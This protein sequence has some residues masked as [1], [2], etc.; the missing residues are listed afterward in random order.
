MG[1]TIFAIEDYSDI[2][3]REQTGVVPEDKPRLFFA[4]SS[5]KGPEE[6][7]RNLDRNTVE[8]LYITNK[9]TIFQKHG[10]P[11]LGTASCVNSGGLADC[12]RIV[13][14]DSKLAHICIAARVK[15]E[16]VPDIAGYSA[17]GDPIYQY[18]MVGGGITTNSSL[19][20]PSLPDPLVYKSVAMITY[21]ASVLS[22]AGNDPDAF[23][24][25]FDTYCQSVAPD[26]RNVYPT[27]GTEG[28]YP[29]FVLTDN[30]RGVSNKKIVLEADWSRGSHT[31]FMKYILKVF[32]E[33][34]KLENYAFSFNQD[35]DENKVNLSISNIVR[36][37][38]LQIRCRQFD[39]QLRAFSENVAFIAGITSEDFINSDILNALDEN[40]EQYDKIQISTSSI[41]FSQGIA[42]LNGDNG[43]FGDSPLESVTYT[44]RLVE[45]FNGS[46]DVRNYDEIYD[47]DNYRI[48]AIFDQ[49]YPEPVKRAI[50]DL[51]EFRQDCFY[52]RDM[53]LGLT[54]L[55]Q[56]Q[57]ANT[58]NL[59]SRF[60]ATY[61]NSWDIEDPFSYKPITVT[62][63][64]SLINR[65]VT[66]FL[67]GV[68]RPFAGIPFN[69]A[70]TSDEIIEGSVN[71]N[72]KNVPGT[73]QI[74]WFKDNRINY[75]VYYNGTLSMEAE[76]TSQTRN[77]Q[78]TWIN[79]V[80]SLQAIM[81][82]VRMWCPK[83]RYR[84]ITTKD[85]SDYQNDV[86]AVLEKHSGNYQTLEL[87]YAKDANYE[88]N[89]I[90]Y[91]YIY[92]R[93]YNHIEDEFFRIAVLKTNGSGY[94]DSIALNTGSS[95]S[96]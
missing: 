47:L 50:E 34:R 79:N 70:W 9:K 12:K 90:Y 63:T 19:A 48:D 13:A 18:Y 91:A 14:T 83:N 85:L 57:Y 3:T 35:I 87:V 39:R 36:K 77:T 26:P 74:Q 82:D 56:I 5:D 32:E 96:Y 21:E 2:E 49:N 41:D 65:F 29:L 44:A 64:Y 22:I 40:M 27:D 54:S 31:D 67:N 78:L 61:H 88:N 52:F 6:Y 76:F 94:E 75:A 28:Y 59:K 62:A 69:I 72:P 84:W 17:T 20:D 80:L 45:A 7:K 51:V 92:V 43:D 15:K 4:F 95:T 60:C 37:Y 66:H 38:G 42:L 33:G 16:N 55:G 81:R 11:L 86:N 89:K 24:T 68:S 93:F 73:D 10:Q 53:G 25:A 23:A 30:G 46:S 8:A 58:V 1:R 71:F